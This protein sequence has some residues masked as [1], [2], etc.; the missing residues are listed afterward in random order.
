[1]TNKCK[2]TRVFLIYFKKRDYYFMQKNKLTNVY[3]FTNKKNKT[4]VLFYSSSNNFSVSESFNSLLAKFA[5]N[6]LFA[7]SVLNLYE[8]IAVIKT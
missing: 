5:S 4:I 1:M 6:F 3:K 7:L 8:L 2:I